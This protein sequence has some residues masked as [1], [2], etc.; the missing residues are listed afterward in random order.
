MSFG[1]VLLCHTALER[2]A[3]AARFWAAGGAPVVIH[4]DARVPQAELSLM[5]A[6][7]ATCPMFSFAGA[8][9]AIGAAGRW[10]RRRRRRP[11]S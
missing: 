10:L 11:R 6:G 8:G 4:V 7:L 9:N 3:Q 5:Q 1:V 2:A